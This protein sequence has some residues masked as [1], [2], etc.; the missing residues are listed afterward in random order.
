MVLIALVITTI[1]G[2]VLLFMTNTQTKLNSLDKQSK[3]SF[4]YA[5]SGYNKYLWHLNDDPEFYLTQ[6]S[7]DMMNKDIEFQNGFYRLEV[8]RPDDE[9]RFVV[10]KSTG[11][12]KENPDIKRTI[13]AKIRKKQ[14]VHHVY[15]SDSDGDNIWWTKGDESLGPLHTNKDI[16]IQQNPIF[17]DTVSYS[18][19]LKKGTNYSPDFKVKNPLQPEKTNT[20]DFPDHNKDLKTW[21]EK[22]NMV[23]KGRTCIYLDGKN[24]KIR[25][26][27]DSVDKIKTIS[28]SS[29]KNKVIYVEKD[30]GGGTGKFDIKAG[31]IFIS[32][33]LEGELTIGA[34]NN[35]YITYDDPT[36]WYD[37]DNDNMNNFSKKPNQPPQ[38]FKWS[39]GRWRDYPE[40]GGIRYSKTTFSLSNGKM[41]RSANGDD[42]LGL[43]ANNEILI[44]HYGWPKKAYESDLSDDSWNFEW[45]FYDYIDERQY[46]KKGKYY[47][48]I[49]NGNYYNEVDVRRSDYYNVRISYDK[50]LKFN[51]KIDLYDFAPQDITI[52]AALFSINSGFGFESYNRGNPRGEIKIWGNITQRE[53]LPVGSIGY[54]GSVSSG[55]NKEYIH[56]P[57]M[58][59][60]YPPHI[61]EPTN[62]GWEIH[63]WKEVNDHVARK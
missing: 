44:L 3:I 50:W 15:V 29:I 48:I 24:I 7:K 25:N 37:Y 49:I 30:Q 31:N 35:V 40:K 18:G 21:A 43:I 45:R 47:D 36:N 13:I 9:D 27:N 32:G 55:Y 41:T 59:Y 28:I 42:M 2:V 58:L 63:E 62:V 56:D 11:W 39:D 53:R 38:S 61:I 23:F 22:D 16:R 54:N 26:G 14:F 4:E 17:Y 8:E 46:L 1:F 57:R 33:E 6:D 20:L 51:T 52:H 19:Q 10:I 12:T 5:E 60:N 34:E